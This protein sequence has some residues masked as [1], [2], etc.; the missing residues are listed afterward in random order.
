MRHAKILNFLRAQKAAFSTERL[1][2]DQAERSELDALIA[3]I[4]A[5]EVL[6]SSHAAAREVAREKL[7]KWRAA[8]CALSGRAR[9]LKASQQRLR[10]PTVRIG[11]AARS[12]GR[13]V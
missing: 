4:A 9:S 5:A 1:S 8:V 6:I 2:A 12:R 7:G 13:R 11:F 3:D 10:E